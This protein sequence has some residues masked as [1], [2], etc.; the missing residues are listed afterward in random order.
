MGWSIIGN[1]SF[2]FSGDAAKLR[3]EHENLLAS[4]AQMNELLG[5]MIMMLHKRGSVTDEELAQLIQHYTQLAS[6]NLRLALLAARKDRN[7]LTPEE[8]NYL[9]YYVNK[10][11]EGS[12]FSYEEI[13]HYRQLVEAA[14]KEQETNPWPLIALGGFLLGLWLG[15]QRKEE[16][17][18]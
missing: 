6:P 16:D 7:P 4:V 18:R 8:A 5:Q 2:I 11:N 9:E 17:Q 13:D 3:N 12:P 1:I 15:S 10:A 14:K